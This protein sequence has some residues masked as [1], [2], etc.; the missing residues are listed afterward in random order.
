M[1][2][3]LKVFLSVG[4]L[5]T[6]LLPYV[7]AA[8]TV[9]STLLILARDKN[10]TL[11][12]TL[13]LQG[14][15]IPYQ[16]VDLSLSAAGIPQLNS[17]PDAGNFGGIV[18]VS[19][20]DYK[21]GDDWKTI[22]NEKQWQEIYKYQEAFGVR[23]V[24]LNAWPSADFGVQSSGGVITVDQPI[25]V[26]DTS[27]FT[28]AN[29]RANAQTSTLNLTKY[30]AKITNTSLATEIA[31]FSSGSSKTTAAVNNRFPSGREQQVWF[32]AFD[33][34][35]TS[36]T[37]LSHAWIHWITRGLFMGY[38][39]VYLNTQVDDVFVETELYQTNKPYR[40]LPADFQ[41]HV[42]WTKELNSKL[43]AG[44][45]YIIELGH[46]GNGNIEAAVESDYNNEPAQCDPQEG[47]EY[48]TQIDGPPEYVKPIGTG[49]DLWNKKF[50]SYSWSLKCSQ[51]DPLEVYFANK[52]N[53]HSF[54]HVSH[55]FTHEDETNATYADVTKEISWNQAWFK[56]IGFT[57][58]E[59]KPYFSNMGL[60]PP[61]ITGLHNGDALRAW[62]EYGIRYAV[63]DNSR[64]ILMNVPSRKSEYHPVISNVKENGYDGIYIVGRYGSSIYYN[65][66]T[67]SCVN[68]EWKA[69][70]G[71][72]GDF[73]A[74]LEYEKTVNTKYLLGLRWD[75]Y[76]FH[77]ANL[78]V[79]DTKA[80]TL[81]GKNKKWSL[82][83]AWTEA[84][85]YE[86]ARLVEWPVITLKHD[87]T[88]KAIIARKLRD[89]C[90]PSLVYRLSSDRK[91]ITGISLSTLQPECIN[92]IPV[93]V[94]TDVKDSADANR[95][96]RGKDPLTLWITAGIN[97]PRLFDLSTALKF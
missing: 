82:L 80:T 14:Y 1:A 21:N 70:A 29:L 63:G 43:P 37:L 74:Q 5:A 68:S 41:E 56:A 88:A 90:R 58:S 60:I 75:P 20:R 81:L 32:S 85:V 9:N 10:A 15:S 57:D 24:R 34:N 19:A 35:L 2:T 49:K 40:I 39:R 26:T 72:S 93:T 17:T 67:P 83:M 61:G 11:P 42:A 97:S 31:Q 8:V 77:Q 62:S 48:E 44:S 66:D 12:G 89:E 92:D 91:S 16:V 79:S 51:L 18:A 78:R 6:T 95:E 22:L 4:T 36:S 7:N 86:F 46:N 87:D 54:F 59:S 38:R 30:P 65:C 64:P 23:L 84:V 71:G 94:P 96:Q 27:S 13:V 52:T 33:P 3:F 47:V 69:I 53:M 76:M 55:T 73:N 28:T 25:A 50:K 45:N